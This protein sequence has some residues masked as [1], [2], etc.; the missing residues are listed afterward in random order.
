VLL[1]GLGVNVHNIA[2][3]RS[4]GWLLLVLYAAWLGQL[5]GERVLDATLSGFVGAA[6]MVPV[7]HAAARAPHAPP[8]H[9]TILPAFWMLVPGAIGL[10]GITEI[11]GDNV[12]AG[13]ENF[14]RALVSIP[15]VALGVLVGTMAVRAAR[16][17]G[18]GPQ[19]GRR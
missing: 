10:I 18:L 11:V 9:V 2:P 6:V 13:T 16:M 17:A 1:F 4:L 14:L 12:E 7:A 3:P 8:S 15:S 5:A 19:R